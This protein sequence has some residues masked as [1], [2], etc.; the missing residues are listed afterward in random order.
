M[1]L[2]G[3]SVRDLCRMTCVVCRLCI[4]KRRYSAKETYNFIDRT[5]RS[6]PMLT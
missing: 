4:E 5:D 2:R 3:E 6:H 1:T